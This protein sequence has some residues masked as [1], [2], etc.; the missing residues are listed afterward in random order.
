MEVAVNG[1]FVGSATLFRDELMVSTNENHILRYR[2]D[3]TINTDYCI[4]LRR[5]P[6]SI[7]QQASRAVPITV[8][9][10]SP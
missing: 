3:G 9:T 4:D 1:E 10:S 7:D 5:V 2:W 8:I 6:F